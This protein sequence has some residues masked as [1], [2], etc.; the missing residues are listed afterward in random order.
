MWPRFLVLT[1]VTALSALS[2]ARRPPA[3][4]GPGSV[5]DFRQIQITAVSGGTHALP[6]LLGKRPALISFWA[7]WC[8]PCIKELPE[9]EQLAN[10]VGP[11]GATVLGV[12]VGESPGSIAKFM[13][14]RQLSYPQFTDEQFRL[15]DALGNGGSPP[16][17]CS[18]E[19]SRSS[20]SARP[21]TGGRRARSPAPWAKP[22][23]ARPARRA[24]SARCNNAAKRAAQ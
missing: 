13:R 1:I 2:C 10:T 22:R 8:E 20:T 14:A 21:S 7:P 6:E 9:L 5:E 11:C 16:R 18:M 19:I 24:R 3:K 23:A 15:A 4:S 12:A 17:S